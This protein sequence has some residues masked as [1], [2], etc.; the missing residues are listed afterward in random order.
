MAKAGDKDGQRLTREQSDKMFAIVYMMLTMSERFRTLFAG[1]MDGRND[2]FIALIDSGTSGAIPNVPRDNIDANNGIGA[3]ALVY[4]NPNET[5]L[6]PV[7]G[8][9]VPANPFATLAHELYHAHE[10]TTGRQ[11]QNQSTREDNAVR[12]EN[13]FR[14]DAAQSDFTVG[15]GMQQRD[16][17]QAP[18]AG[19]KKAASPR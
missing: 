19:P 10:I 3:A 18:C 17:Y 13:E 9:V 16:C 8:G 4:Y 12:F 5:T 7:G 15:R 6:L 11:S 2:V 1:L 14:R